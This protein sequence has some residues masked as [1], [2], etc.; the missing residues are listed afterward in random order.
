MEWLR[1]LEDLLGY[2][3]QAMELAPVEAALRALVVY[4]VVLAILRLGEKRFLGRNTAFDV[5]L[6]IMVGSIAARSIT[7]NAPVVPAIV[8][9]AVLVA[10][11]WLAASLA[12]RYRGVGKVI[13]GRSKEL[14]R[15]GE[16]QEAA[17]AESDI[18][19]NDLEEAMRRQGV[20]ELDQVATAHLERNGK[21]SVVP[22]GEE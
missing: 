14:V 8:A 3:E 9:I 18:T 5:V 11:H 1:G 16:I 10:V 20:T 12:Y 19:R 6:A 22:K 15:D 21:V 7:G 13:K 2:R 4:V 17:M